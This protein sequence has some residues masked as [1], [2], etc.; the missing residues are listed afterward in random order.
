VTL[1]G[2]GATRSADDLYEQ[3]PF[4]HV[5]APEVVPGDYV[6]KWGWQLDLNMIYIN[7]MASPA[8]HQL[9]R[10]ARIIWPS[11]RFYDPVAA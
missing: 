7:T 11:W 2:L 6:W 4:V 5:V 10:R 8:S 3:V 1:K 9:R